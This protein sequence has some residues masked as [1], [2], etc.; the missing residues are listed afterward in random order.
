[1]KVGDDGE[2]GELDGEPQVF[3]MDVDEHFAVIQDDSEH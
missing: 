3:V 1:M 2:D